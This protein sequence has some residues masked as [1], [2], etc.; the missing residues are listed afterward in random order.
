ML[1]VYGTFEKP[2]HEQQFMHIQTCRLRF[3]HQE[4][5]ALAIRLVRTA[6]ATALGV[7]LA[8]FPTRSRSYHPFR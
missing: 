2:I 6:L 7:H 3:T 1:H 4:H 5:T 8:R